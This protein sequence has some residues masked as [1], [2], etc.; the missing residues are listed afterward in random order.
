[1][2]NEERKRR[3]DTMLAHTKAQLD[4]FEST[5][6]CRVE[7]TL[8]DS[9]NA[10]NCLEGHEAWW[11]EHVGPLDFIHAQE[12]LQIAER[13]RIDVI[14]IVMGVRK[15]ISRTQNEIENTQKKGA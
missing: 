5:H 7:V 15:A 8:A 14:R 2:T 4:A 9:I 12:A 1:M 6:R 3:D 10:G 11:R 13:T